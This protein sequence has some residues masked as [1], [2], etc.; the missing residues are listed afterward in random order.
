MKFQKEISELLTAG[1]ISNDTADNI[2]HYYLQKKASKPNWLITVFAILGGLLIGLGVVLIIAHNWDD[3]SKTVRSLLAFTPLVIGQ[4]IIIFVFN[5]KRKNTAWRESSTTFLIFAI[6]GCISLI[7][8]IY[9]IPGNISAFMLTWVA[10]SLPL[11][12]LMKSSLA[13][14]LC[15]AGITYYAIETGYASYDSHESYYYW[16]LLLLIV[17]HYM[18]LIKQNSTGNF[19]IYHHWFIPLSFTI[20]LGIMADHNE[21]LMYIAYT[22]MF[23]LFLQIGEHNTFKNGALR[24]NGYKII[25]SLGTIILL[26]TMSFDWFWK[27]MNAFENSFIEIITSNELMIS[28]AF[29]VITSLFAFKSWQQTPLKTIKPEEAIYIIVV[30]FY[31]IP[32][33]PIVLTILTNVIVLSIGIITIAQGTQK[34][35][36]GIL[37]YGL[38]IITALVICRFF[39]TDLSFI[40]RGILFIGV[41]FGFFIANY[42]FLKT[43]QRHEK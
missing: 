28:L 8:Q 18:S 37:N 10:L 2:N 40:L 1:V 27:D 36:L 15:I 33:I 24:N 25:G 6:G 38:L 26:L 32:G 29:V 42:R 20:C 5:K 19:A 31:L 9:N 7:S 13:S 12:Y 11:I 35:Q 41:G 3:L 39:D 43:K 16:V 14:L 17:P 23:A 34:R 30:L 21:E 22:S 4:A